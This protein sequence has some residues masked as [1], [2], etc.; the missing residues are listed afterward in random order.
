MAD[1][2]NELQTVGEGQLVVSSAVAE[3]LDNL[4]TDGFENV[5]AEDSGLTILTIL[6]SNSPQCTKGDDKFIKGAESGQFHNSATNAVY[7]KLQ[8][9]PIGFNKAYV[10]WRP[11]TAGGGFVGI[12]SPGHPRVAQA[13]QVGNKLITNDGNELVET[14]QHFVIVLPENGTP[15]VALLPLKSTQLRH[16]RRWLADM[17]TKVIEGPKG[18]QRLPMFFQVY[19]LETGPE[20]NSKGSWMGLTKITFKGIVPDDLINLAKTSAESFNTVA[21]NAAAAYD[22]ASPAGG[23]V[24]DTTVADAVAAS[25]E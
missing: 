6:Q 4:T 19:E 16:S 24:V 17:Q 23:V 20:S 15:F 9:I 7:D 11:R 21:G 2:K 1:S 25:M 18:P 14:A 3:Q 8:V 10:E 5:S 13:Q 22:K 12:F